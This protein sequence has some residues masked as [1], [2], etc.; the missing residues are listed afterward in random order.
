MTKLAM[1]C[2]AMDVV[3]SAK[4]GGETAAQHYKVHIRQEEE[5][6]MGLHQRTRT[7]RVLSFWCFNSAV[8][9]DSLANAGARSIILTSGTLSPLDSF[10]FELGM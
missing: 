5:R 2:D 10:A 7:V 8:A 1:F 4:D 9:M 3:F 6:G